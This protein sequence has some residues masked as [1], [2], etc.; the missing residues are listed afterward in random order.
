VEEKGYIAITVS[1]KIGDEPIKPQSV[2]IAEIKEMINDV[3]TFL[4]P[5][6]AEKNERPPPLG[7][8]VVRLRVGGS[9]VT[10][11]KQ[12]PVI[13]QV[14]QRRNLYSTPA[15]KRIIIFRIYSFY[16]LR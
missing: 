4:Y 11:F 10:S 1:G 9:L 16:C 7:A 5:G 12:M 3:E 6:R 13:A 14:N 8:S 2:D 15:L